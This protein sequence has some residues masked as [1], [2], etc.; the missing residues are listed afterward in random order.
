MESM[1]LGYVI[2][3]V[4]DVVK[5]VSFYEQAFGL[6]RMFVHE[7]G[8][9][10]QMDTG[11]TGLCFCAEELAGDA[12]SFDPVRP[13]RT[14]PGTEIGFVT[15]DVAAAF[16]RAVAAGAT[17]VLKPIEKPWGQTVSYVRDLNGFLVEI[18]SPMSG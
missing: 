1:K 17:V 13:E 2:H 15:N 16:E 5:A 14:P 4:P 8:Q 18:C 7:S 10:A 12:V 3:Y 6:T 9:F 11:T